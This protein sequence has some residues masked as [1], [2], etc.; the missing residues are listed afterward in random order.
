MGSKGWCCYEFIKSR[1][2]LLTYLSKSSIYLVRFENLVGPKGGGS[3]Q[4]QIHELRSLAQFLEYE[5]K[6]FE[7][8]ADR[9]WG[10]SPTFSIGKIGRWREEMNPFHIKMYKSIYQDELIYLKYETSREWSGTK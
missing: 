3:K 9:L 4:K 5:E 8:I 10:N 6:K 2:K 1:L 7:K